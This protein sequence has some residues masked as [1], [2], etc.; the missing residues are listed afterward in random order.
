MKSV[1][2][3]F[4]SKGSLLTSNVCLPTPQPVMFTEILL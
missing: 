3:L 2:S 1:S 4:M